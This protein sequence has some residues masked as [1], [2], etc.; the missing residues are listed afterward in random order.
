MCVC[1]CVLP[2]HEHLSYVSL[3][4]RTTTG[5]VPPQPTF[6]PGTFPS[7][8][9]PTDPSLTVRIWE[10]TSDTQQ[11]NLKPGRCEDIQVWTA[12][13]GPSQEQSGKQTAQAD[14]DDKAEWGKTLPEDKH[15]WRMRPCQ[16][17]TMPPS[18]LLREG[19]VPAWV[20]GGHTEH[21]YKSKSE[22]PIIYSTMISPSFLL[23]ERGNNEPQHRAATGPT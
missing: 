11:E 17:L 4:C 14:E 20:P 1:T 9:F 16:G 21:G 3:C 8:H 13:F 15:I 18:A 19:E 5:P 22:C 7:G 12:P 2:P 6:S 10:P 23:L